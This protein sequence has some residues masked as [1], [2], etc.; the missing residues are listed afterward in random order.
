LVAALSKEVDIL[1][2]LLTARIGTVL[3][4]APLMVNVTG[5]AAT[6]AAPTV[7]VIVSTAEL[8]AVAV[9]AIPVTALP[10]SALM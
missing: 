1:I 4:V 7:R 8:I 9:A 2:P 6:P 10:A 5:P 3:I